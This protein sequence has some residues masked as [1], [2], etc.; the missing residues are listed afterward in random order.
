M[1]THFL[2]PE[3]SLWIFCKLNPHPLQSDERMAGAPPADPT[4]RFQ[5]TKEQFI[6]MK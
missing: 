2:P 1:G 3:A 5:N 4:W 6:I